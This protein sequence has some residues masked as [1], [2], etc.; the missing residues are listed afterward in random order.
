VGSLPEFEGTWTKEPTTEEMPKVLDLIDRVNKLKELG[1]TGISVAANWLA[2]RV[3]PLKKQVHPAWEYNGLSDPTY[4]MS[5][6]MTKDELEKLL[7]KMF[8]FTNSWPTPKEVRSFHIQVEH[9]VVRP[10][11]KLGFSFILTLIAFR[12]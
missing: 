1:L 2:R 4:K 8:T 6:R 12:F 11:F 7:D 10:L 5:H 9:D 3:V